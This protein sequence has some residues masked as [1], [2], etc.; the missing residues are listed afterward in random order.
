MELGRHKYFSEG[1]L[2]CVITLT[3]YLADQPSDN[4]VTTA[5]VFKTD[6]E[7]NMFCGVRLIP[8]TY[9]TALG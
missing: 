7:L 1:V 6:V 9:V 4:I 5:G 3:G 2:D 8:V